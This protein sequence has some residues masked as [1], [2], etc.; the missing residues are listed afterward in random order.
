MPVGEEVV[1]SRV[2]SVVEDSIVVSES[3]V[4]VAVVSDVEVERVVNA[5][6]GSVEAMLESCAT[7]LEVQ[8]KTI[9][10]NT[11]SSPRCFLIRFLLPTSFQSAHDWTN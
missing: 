7:S 3:P 8:A 4:V 11:P 5:A 6:A 1:V 10:A 2:V 9:N